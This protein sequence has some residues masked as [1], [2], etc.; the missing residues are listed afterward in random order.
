MFG[1]ASSN[2]HA[3]LCFQI[4]Q[5][6]QLTMELKHFF[7][8]LG[9]I[10]SLSPP[11]PQGH[12]TIA[13]GLGAAQD[14]KPNVPCKNTRHQDVLNYLMLVTKGTSF[15]VVHSSLSKLI[16]HPTSIERGQPQ[17]EFTA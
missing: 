16:S 14:S 15:R 10:F 12:N 2:T 13:S 3:F 8:D 4:C 7:F 1:E 9:T 6:T 17:E 5:A 11:F